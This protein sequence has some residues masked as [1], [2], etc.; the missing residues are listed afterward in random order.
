MNATPQVCIDPVR[1]AECL[2]A[3]EAYERTVALKQY[4]LRKLILTLKCQLQVLEDLAATT[5][6][7][8]AAA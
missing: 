3:A 6:D 1:L 8:R 7:R 2:A 4:R 5:S